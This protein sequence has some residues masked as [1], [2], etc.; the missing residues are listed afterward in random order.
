VT[1]V[2]SVAVKIYTRKGDDGTTGL[3]YG[4][5]VGKDSTGPEAYG[6]VDEAVS[7]LGIARAAAG[8]PLAGAI[9]DLQRQCFVVAAEL[10]TDPAARG[11]LVPGVSLCTAEMV[12]SLESAIDRLTEESGMPTGFV[13][14]GGNAPAA[15]LDLARTIVRRAER[16]A[17]GHLAVA[18]IDDSQVVPFLNRAADY[19]YMLARAAEGT[20]EPSRPKEA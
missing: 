1:S 9:L 13:V 10:A 6:T 12:A 11:K 17:V 16:R 7:A 4:G 3:F 18:G 20:W 14:P 8:E 2:Q 5:R 15:A 19:L